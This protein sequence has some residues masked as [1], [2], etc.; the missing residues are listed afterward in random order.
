MDKIKLLL[1]EDNNDLADAMK[2]SLEYRGDYDVCTAYDGK[3]GL[4]LYKSFNPDIIVADIEM[5]V[6]DGTEMVRRIREKDVHTPVIFLTGRK[7][8]KDC[9]NGLNIGADFYMRKPVSEV[10]LDA[11]MRALLKR[12]SPK[13]LP[14]MENG[15][16]VIGMFGFSSP[17]KYLIRNGKLIELSKTEA[18]ILDL[19]VSKKGQLVQREN[20][21]TSL[22]KNDSF[23]SARV[24]D[25]QILNLRKKLAEDALVKIIT[26]R[27][28]GYILKDGF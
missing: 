4:D 8:A 28:E 17:G 25:I 1:V 16:C 24:L 10:E 15:E 7:A 23:F 12:V 6:M 20:I 5:P 26:V 27:G 21:Y 3:E 19:L 13:G 22:G 2:G 18:K 9:V 11:Q 14:V